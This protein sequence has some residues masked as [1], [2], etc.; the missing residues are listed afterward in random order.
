MAA[1][2]PQTSEAN[3]PNFTGMSQGTGPDRTFETLF[4]GLVETA[5]NVLKVKD[6]QN[7]L[8]IQQDAQAAFEQTNEEFGVAAPQGL[9]DELDRMK[10]LQNAVSQGKI[11]QVNYYG[12]L[13]TLSKQLRTKY[14]GYEQ[15]VD[16]TIQSVTGTRP[17][18]AYR[19]ALFQEMANV[20]EGASNEVKF[21]RQYEKEN[22]AELALIFG[23]DYFADP[24][25]YDFDQVR[26]KVAS[27]KS[28][29]LAIDSET[30]EIGLMSKRGEF[31]DTRA[32]KA[33][34]QDFSFVAEATL[35]KSLGLNNPSA[36]DQINQF[37]EKGGGSPEELNAFIGN[38][39]AI[40]TDLRAQLTTRGRQQYVSTGVLS[41]DDV[42]RAV[43]AALYPITKAK[44]AVLGGDF[45][46][47]ARYATVSKVAQD[48]QMSE[49][50]KDPEF[51]AG[52]GL[53]A[54]SQTLGDSFFNSR[55]EKFETLALEVAGRTM[56]GQAD[57]VKKTVE[58]G[59]QKVTREVLSQTFKAIVDPKLT[60]EQFTNVIDQYFGPN[61]IDFMSPKVVSPSDLEPLFLQ[62]VRPEVTAAIVQK[63]T[64]EDLKKYTAWAMEKV[65]AIPAF[66]AAAGETGT[67]RS[68][69]PDI[70]F[71]FDPTSF[72]FK[73][74][75]P[76]VLGGTSVKTTGRTL[77]A[78]N[79]VMT[80][81][82]P[83]YEANGDKEGLEL[84]KQTIKNLNIDL[85][86]GAKGGFWDTILN[87][88]VGS[89][90]ASE[91][92]SPEGVQLASVAGEDDNRIDFITTNAID[93]TFGGRAT[94]PA[95]TPD[96]TTN[97]ILDGIG[98]AEGAGYDTLFANSQRKFG[99][100][101]STM[102][103]GE[104]MALQKR[105][106]KSLG[107]SAA[108][109]Y[110]IMGYTLKDAVK[111][112]GLSKDEVFSEELQDRIAVEY[113]LKRRGYDDYKA[114][115]I[116]KTRFLNNLALEWASLP[117][118]SGLSAYHGDKMGNKAT[119]KGKQLYAQMSAML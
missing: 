73:A 50:L 78:L 21:R 58:S 68:M 54:I 112:M 85:E 43:E 8:D 87:T 96:E 61:A 44:E 40:E 56:S 74:Y 103:I 114:G 101:P 48:E 23:D 22:E 70:K 1:F 19:D 12:R 118:S 18:N 25:K 59:N 49:M 72:Q 41:Q 116:S 86:G 14:P 76:G 64:A 35:S 100:K 16:A 71:E 37:V 119:K 79:K 45:K 55:S 104:L 91:G 92:A 32:K 84:A 62:F 31:N 36:F 3:I 26:S 107:S 28:K 53:Q 83:I 66:R 109:K 5:G 29:K 117:T 111:A 17:A 4:S 89:A 93:T 24:T 102:T 105:M 108:G 77:D 11:S 95:S 6:Q 46:L 60:G 94:S 98:A 38:I 110:Q 13:A 88:I 47:A 30:A 15:I 80:V 20:S 115:K 34:D 97:N 81:M 2:N 63:G 69:N 57:I 51:K 27:F 65:S 67:L 39:S 75:T 113:L 52:Q 82:K 106:S 42:N 7:Q 10:S 90:D 33:I 9:T 99:V